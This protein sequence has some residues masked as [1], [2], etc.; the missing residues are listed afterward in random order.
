[1]RLDASRGGLRVRSARLR[2]CREVACCG[3]ECFVVVSLSCTFR[4]QVG[5]G[6]T[7]GPG[8][9]WCPCCRRGWPAARPRVGRPGGFGPP[10]GAAGWRLPFSAV[11]TCGPDGTWFWWLWRAG[12]ALTDVNASATALFFGA[13]LTQQL[14]GQQRASALGVSRGEGLPARHAGGLPRR[15]TWVGGSRVAF[16]AR[17]LPGPP[18]RCVSVG[19]A[20]PGLQRVW[21]PGAGR[22]HRDLM[23][24]GRCWAQCWPGAGDGGR[25]CCAAGALP[26]CALGSRLPAWQGP[27]LTAGS[28]RVGPSGRSSVSFALWPVGRACVPLSVAAQPPA[29]SLRCG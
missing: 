28:P 9:G 26:G 22:D 8:S 17:R 5:G 1:V 4:P 21:Q 3:P 25:L 10:P 13:S 15:G 16:R 20:L 6:C 14:G 11:V 29:G 24:P 23:V 18:L 7:L 27:D 12:L 2:R 19:R